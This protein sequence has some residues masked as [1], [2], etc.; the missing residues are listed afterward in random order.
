[1]PLSKQTLLR[2]AASFSSAGPGFSPPGQKVVPDPIVEL[3]SP[4][5]VPDLLHPAHLIH[6]IV[7]L[8][9][10]QKGTSGDLLVS[11]IIAAVPERAGPAPRVETP[12]FGYAES[13]PRLDGVIRGVGRLD[14]DGQ[15]GGWIHLKVV[16]LGTA[17]P[18][19]IATEMKGLIPFQPS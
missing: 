11:P 8:E 13:P 9:R 2:G 7:G 10:R 12:D 18:F 5:D 15:I 6:D 19:G 16:V 4:L 17:H 3:C 1:G 14:L